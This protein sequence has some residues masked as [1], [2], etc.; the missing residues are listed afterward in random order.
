MSDLFQPGTIPNADPQLVIEEVTYS[1]TGTTIRW[2]SQPGISYRIQWKNMLLDNSWQTITPDIAGT[3]SDLSW[4]DDGTQT[5]GLGAA[6][7]F[8]RL[9]VP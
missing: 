8:Y 7:R 4:T 3:G 5:G 9:V 2:T 1:A 6:Q